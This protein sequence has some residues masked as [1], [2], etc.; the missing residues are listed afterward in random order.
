MRMKLLRKLLALRTTLL[1]N[2]SGRQKPVVLVLSI[3]EFFF[4]VV[5]F[6][7]DC[8]PALVTYIATWMGV[9]LFATLAVFYL[10]DRDDHRPPSNQ[11]PDYDKVFDLR[12]VHEFNRK[13]K[14]L[15]RR[16][17]SGATNTPTR[18]GPDTPRD[19]PLIE[20]DTPRDENLSPTA[21]IRIDEPDDE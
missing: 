5:L 4:L 14:G 10:I 20:P 9:L 15:S 1:E 16:R 8:P 3:A 7:Q 6:T 12:D 2:F 17:E 13:A 19:E 18:T 21:G 11:L